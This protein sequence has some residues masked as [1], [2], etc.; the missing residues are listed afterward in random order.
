MKGLNF[1]TKFVGFVLSVL[2]LA[3]CQQDDRKDIEDYYFPIDELREG[4][5]YEYRPIDQDS[6]GSD[7]WYYSKLRKDGK[8]YFIG[9][10]YDA[11]MNVRQFFREEK[12]ADGMLLEEMFLYA[13]DSLGKSIQIPVE[14]QAA[15]SY[16]FK[17]SEPSGIFLFKVKWDDPNDPESHTTLIRNRRYVG[18]TTYV[19]Q[20]KTYDCIKMELRELVENYVA[21]E[22]YAEPE[23]SGLELYAEGLGLVYYRRNISNNFVLEY[24]LVDTYSMEKLEESLK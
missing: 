10:Y 2:L 3:T 7:Y 17:V 9:N 14:I 21:G 12:I 6:I 22:G 4:K 15:N 18:D 20:G 23:Y 11:A 1:L 5:V 24:E 16:P 8:T 13:S 19:Y